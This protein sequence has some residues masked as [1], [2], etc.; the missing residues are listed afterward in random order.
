[1]KQM[2]INNMLYCLCRS[3]E[4]LCSTELTM[5]RCTAWQLKE[6]RKTKTESNK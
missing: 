1:M 5:S 4:C 3:F 6:R 2:R